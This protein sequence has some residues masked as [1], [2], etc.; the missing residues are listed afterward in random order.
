MADLGAIGIAVDQPPNR[1][2]YFYTYTSPVRLAGRHPC[3]D[4]G[5]RMISSIVRHSDGG[6][7]Q[8]PNKGKNKPIT[9]TTALNST[10]TPLALNVM[11]KGGLVKQI[12]STPDVL[13]RELVPGDYEITVYGDGTKRSETWGYDTVDDTYR[14]A[15]SGTLDPCSSGVGYA[16]G[17]TRVG[18]YSPWVWDIWN[19]LPTGLSFSTSTGEISGSTTQTGTYKLTIGVRTDDGYRVYKDVTLTVA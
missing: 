13:I 7:V 10:N 11:Y 17:L 16:S 5:M 1:C 15:L 4:T 18:G 12:Q 2:R 6:L 9:G 3:V 19:P 14:L 8:D